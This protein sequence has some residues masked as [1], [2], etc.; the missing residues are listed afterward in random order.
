[1]LNC[2]TVLA[3]LGLFCALAVALMATRHENWQA[4]VDSHHVLYACKV[5][6]ALPPSVA[7]KF[8]DYYERAE[9]QFRTAFESESPV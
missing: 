5:A 6:F 1:M 3:L 2:T 7:K 9:E 8:M 4:A